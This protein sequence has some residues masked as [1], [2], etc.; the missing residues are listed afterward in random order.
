M[1]RHVISGQ[2]SAARAALRLAVAPVNGG[3]AATGP[4]AGG[5]TPPPAARARRRGAARAEEAAAAAAAAVGT[6]RRLE[7]WHPLEGLE[8][9]EGLF[10]SAAGAS[11]LA[12]VLGIEARR[13]YAHG[14][15][16]EAE[17]VLGPLLGGLPCVLSLSEHLLAAQESVGVSSSSSGSALGNQL[18]QQRAEEV[19]QAARVM[20]KNLCVTF[21]QNN[22]AGRGCHIFGEYAPA[23]SEGMYLLPSLLEDSSVRGFFAQNSNCSLSVCVPLA[24]RRFG[25]KCPPRTD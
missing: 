6:T 8:S 24:C 23:C 13:E 12:A 11:A 16:L 5:R 25:T 9:L 18:A 2:P 1:V 7:A 15:E 20:K 14:K 19:S 4:A 10:R 17:S 22:Q 21:T 3:T